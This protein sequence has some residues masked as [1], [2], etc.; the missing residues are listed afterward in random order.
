MISGHVN[1]HLLITIHEL[2]NV[3]PHAH[4][5]LYSILHIFSCHAAISALFSG[6]KLTLNHIPLE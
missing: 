6:Q 1:S 4:Y 2:I 5:Q 3:F